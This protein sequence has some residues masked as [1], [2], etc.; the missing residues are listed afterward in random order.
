MIANSHFNSDS[1]AFP[2]Y[3]PTKSDPDTEAEEAE[4]IPPIP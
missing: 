3:S 2:Q 4:N 1:S